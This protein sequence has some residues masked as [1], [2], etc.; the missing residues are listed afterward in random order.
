MDYSDPPVGSE[1][2]GTAAVRDVKGES[3]HTRRSH[4]MN[5][6][7]LSV[8]LLVISGLTAAA[9]PAIAADPPPVIGDVEGQP[10]A[11]NAERLTKALE[12]LGTPLA[13]GVAKELKTAIDAKDAKKVQQLLDPHVL[14]VVNINPEARVK[15]G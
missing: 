9:R 15:V 12:F 3:P 14:F 6:R 7:R 13:E 5:G 1:N 11:A 10:L 8:V 2:R 4:A